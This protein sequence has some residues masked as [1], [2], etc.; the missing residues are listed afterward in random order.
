MP[1]QSLTREKIS[2]LMRHQ[3]YP[4]STKNTKYSLNLFDQ[5]QFVKTC[6]ICV[7]SFISLRYKRMPLQSLT[8]HKSAFFCAISFIRVPLKIPSIRLIFSIKLNFWKPVQSLC[9]FAQLTFYFV[10]LIIVQLRS[11]SY[12]ILRHPSFDIR[13]S[14]FDFL[15][16][17]FNFFLLHFVKTLSPASLQNVT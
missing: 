6:A 12:F 4:R 11:G 2:V 3:F 1:L 13:R 8:L 5:T 17:T 16:S 9:F 15:L 10:F 7:F 14:S